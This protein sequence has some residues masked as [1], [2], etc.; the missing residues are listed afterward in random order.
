M[1]AGMVDLSGF[2]V[3]AEERKI[4][5]TR[6]NVEGEYIY[7]G[8]QQR[9][10]MAQIHVYYYDQIGQEK[11]MTDE[12][13]E[14]LTIEYGK[15]ID[16]GASGKVIV[17]AQDESL[18]TGSLEGGFTIKPKKLTADMIQTIESVMVEGTHNAEA[19]VK[20]IDKD[21]QDENR[22][23]LQENKD[24]RVVRFENNSFTGENA[25][26]SEITAKVIIQAVNG[27]NYETESD[28]EKTFQ[29]FKMDLEKLT[30]EFVASISGDTDKLM[31]NGEGEYFK[32]FTGSAVS[33][34]KG[35]E[36]KVYY[37]KDNNPTPLE[38]TDYELNY[39]PNKGNLP[40]VGDVTVNVNV[41]SGK[42]AGLVSKSEQ[43]KFYIRR[44]LTNTEGIS[45]SSSI[46]ASLLD[47]SQAEV[48]LSTLKF[49]DQFASPELQKVLTEHPEEVFVATLQ[50]GWQDELKKGKTEIPWFFDLS[51]K[52]G[53]YSKYYGNQIKNIPVT[54]T[55]PQ[56]TSNMIHIK[57]GVEIRFN[58]TT[59]WLDDIIA[60]PDNYIE[61][62]SAGGTTYTC[63]K[64]Y[65]VEKARGYESQP[66]LNAGTY[67]ITITPLTTGQLRGEPQ[68][69]DIVVEK[70]SLS[71][72]KNIK[73]EVGNVTYTW[74]KISEPSIK[75]QYLN[76]NGD[77][78]PMNRNQDYSVVVPSVNAA[79]DSY[80]LLNGMT[81][82]S[83][84]N[85]QAAYKIEPWDIFAPG[86][87]V[88]LGD[89][90]SELQYNWGDDVTPPGF[91]VTLEGRTLNPGTDYDVIYRNSKGGTTNSEHKYVSNGTITMYV[92]GKGNFTGSNEDSAQSFTIM[93]RE[94]KGSEVAVRA[95]PDQ[96]YT[97]WELKPEIELYRI[98]GNKTI[99]EDVGYEYIN[100]YSNNKDISHGADNAKVVITGNNNLKGTL[101]ASFNIVP[102]DL[103]NLSGL[104]VR[105]NSWDG[106]RKYD[107]VNG[108][109]KENFYIYTGQAI[110]LQ[111]DY[112]LEIRRMID[113]SEQKPDEKDITVEVLSNTEIGKGTIRISEGE[114]GNYTGEKEVYFSIKG[115][116]SDW[117]TGYEGT[118]RTEIE[119]PD[120]VYT[121][122]SIVPQ[123]AVV[124]FRVGDGDTAEIKTLVLG[125]HYTVKNASSETPPLAT[126]VNEGGIAVFTGEDTNDELMFVNTATESFNVLPFDMGQSD[127]VLEA[128]DF[129]AKLEETD[130][131]YSGYPITPKPKITHSGNPV[132]TTT[133]Y[134]LSYYY[135]N[136][137][138]G[139][140][141][142]P[143]EITDTNNPSLFG[144]GDYRVRIT[145]NTNYTGYTEKNY[146][147]SSYEF[148]EDPDADPRVSIVGTEDGYVVLD[149]I[150][151]PDEYSV[152][153]AGNAMMELNEDGEVTDN[154]IWDPNKLK[155]AFTPV[156]MA[157]EAQSPVD[158]VLDKDYYVTYENNTKPG[159][160]TLV[161]HGIGNFAGEIREDFQI[162]ADLGG[163]HTEVRVK[164][165]T[166]TPANEGEEDANKPEVTVWYTQEI[167]GVKQEPEALEADTYTVEYANNESATHPYPG[168]EAESALDPNGNNF[169]Q[170]TVKAK[171]DEY[172]KYTGA[173]FGTKTEGFKIYQRDLSTIRP[174][175][176]TVPE[177]PDVPDI[178]DTSDDSEEYPW[179]I[180]NLQ[181]GYE[182]NETHIIPDPAIFCKQ[183][184][185]N[186]EIQTGDT[187]PSGDY[188]YRIWAE[189]NLNVWTFENDDMSGKRLLPIFTVEARRDAQ[190]KY[191]GNYCGKVSQNFKITPRPLEEKIDT[192]AFPIVNDRIAPKGIVLDETQIADPNGPIGTENDKG[193]WECDY[194]RT[195]ITF[196]TE[197][198]GI[199]SP[200]KNGALH[201]KWSGDGAKY[202]DL[203]EGQDYNIEYVDNV[204]IGDA[205]IHIEAPEISNYAG[206]Y[207]KHFKI[208]ASITEVDNKNPVPPGRYIELSYDA[209]VPYGKVATYPDLIFK[210]MS[211]VFADSRDEAYILEEGEDKD[212]VIITEKNYQKYGLNEYSQNNIEVTD[213][214]AKA[215]VVVQG[216]GYYKGSIKKEYTIVPKDINDPGIAIEF[217]GSI[218]SGEYKN[219]YIYNGNEQEPEINLYNNNKKDMENVDSE[220]PE[221]KYNP[222][223][224][225]LKME[226]VK[227]NNNGTYISGDYRIR[228]WDN[229]V[230]PVNEKGVAKVLIEGVG[231]NYKGERW[232]EFNIILRQ[233]E[234]LTY[235][236]K[237]PENIIY[238]GA[239]QTPE[240]EVSYDD[241][242]KKVIL[243]QGTDYDLEYSN[244]VD[245]SI[246]A[247]APA[248]GEEQP[249]LP[250]ITF[251]G[252]GG[253]DGT[254]EINFDIK[255]RDIANDEVV[256]TAVAMY[257]SGN[258]VTPNI[259]V[260][261]TGILTGVTLDPEKDYEVVADSQTGE[262]GIAE[263]GTVDIT[264]KGNYTGIKKVTFRIIPPDGV[265][266]I[267]EIPE[268]EFT[269]SPIMPEVQVS[270]VSPQIETPFPLNENDYEVRYTDNLKAGTAKVIITG[271]GAFED[272]GAVEKEFTITPKSIGSEGNIDSAMTLS[273][274]EPQWYGGRP[275]VPGVELK[276]QPSSQQPAE[277][278]GEETNNP[279][280]LIQGTDYRVTAVN[281]IMVGEATATITGIG[282]YTGTIETKFRIHGNM[283]LVDVAPIPT[284]DY[285][286][287]PVTPVP[288][289]SIGGKAMVEGTDYRVEYSDN[290]DRGTATITITG[291]E[292]W[293]FGTKVVKFDIARELS[294]ETAV[295]GV[296]AVYTYTGA[297]ITP[298]VRVEDDGNLL[299]SG[300]DY[301]IA[302][303]ENVNA[304]TATITIT[305]KGKYT[306]GTTA[307]FKISPQ[308]LGR[309]KISPVADQIF[310]G[311]EQN[312]PI[313]VT[314]GNIT[315]QDGK[316]YSVVYVNSATPGMAS[317]IVK[318]EGNYTGTQTV[319]YHIKV[320]EITGVKVSKYT[321]K[322]MTL[323]WTKNDVVSGY[324][325]YNSKNRR[326]ARVNKPTTAKGTVS[327]LKAGTAQT[328]RVRA[329]V[330]KDGQ[331]YYGP[332]SSV[333]G[334]TAPDSTKISS[335]KSAKKKQVTVKW[336]KVKGATQYEV[337][338]SASKKGKYKKLATTKKTSYTDKKA[339]GGK[340]YYY[341]IRVCKKIDKK[342]YYSSYSAAKSVKA[343]K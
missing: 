112:N 53:N 339:T 259:T 30:I 222:Y 189:N 278:E 13:K 239:A 283:N 337:Y 135:Y 263:E 132:E 114:S 139:E 156:N 216:V 285:T 93:P 61:V 107:F 231:K 32:I 249:L 151:Y 237:E 141:Q 28:L 21:I 312:P 229:N 66:G 34:E 252:K 218:V 319:N 272:M 269:N 286:G 42:Y 84:T 20:L 320:P 38:P 198:K 109:W 143:T 182:Y 100:G 287:S 214:G 316:D 33:L 194:T 102:C 63:G 205:K 210:D 164:E 83:G 127:A 311:K 52:A 44:L 295:R 171:Q 318:G 47:D 199:Q 137:E 280:T 23:Q 144:V 39:S 37:D 212:F 281:N 142:T 294:S 77:W 1:I 196:P 335:L 9:P 86:N 117:N 248:E 206:S 101:N 277:R 73:I 334:A 160:A 8:T 11:E 67:K 209:E 253:Y 247:E 152:S 128:A 274:I 24:F 221:K 327:K 336:K 177:S 60:N 116:L 223:Q 161:V 245:V 134:D 298:P 78:T 111:K 153:Y 284:Q 162:L 291:T 323:S 35:E 217:V 328:F 180:E 296:A 57:E 4:E 267:D 321:N 266:T 244:N 95:I 98:S 88:E 342:N 230:G 16:A 6:V 124:K 338:R 92:Q 207:D 242:G 332:F 238:N 91:T 5:L 155:I 58:G 240:V 157:G 225:Q 289:V 185:L 340:K 158:L 260:K 288:Q 146:T 10:D 178:P 68:D 204:K 167:A 43:Y 301:D 55:V 46:T 215:T 308:Q 195:F 246:Q 257:N 75:L 62:K 271:T 96:T 208:M 79:G 115:D 175:D 165:C 264:G 14:K 200:E 306:G 233:M 331:Y 121:N 99:D 310:N 119:I 255:P 265:L 26:K 179:Q 211:G 22:K 131:I 29:V 81:N 136:P 181:A 303:S 184:Q 299:I 325:I 118:K 187:E 317:V 104:I 122:A 97:G 90:P 108:N 133:G 256:A 19:I 251:T 15:N 226:P 7:D 130:Y 300:V 314:S 234:E 154:V 307:S 322:S 330:N 170:A 292:D 31:D 65:K 304:G 186:G 145:G 49:V 190:Q 227:E 203:I 183:V 235:T 293:Y 169:G 191:N 113:S 302:Y 87:R 258:P 159:T 59:R 138:E 105:A 70:I 120:Q 27:G 276:F 188:D 192:E 279:V 36:V 80:V 41:T 273:S 82:F 2:T 275:I 54:I 290:I 40:Y 305:G 125:E 50:R 126:T 270:L 224:P 313:T 129:E 174:E 243:T 282:N 64:D 232:F 149:Q 163:T 254:H 172:G 329:Y 309:A 201:I 193:E 123:D 110:D 89:V 228:R 173:V 72:E 343:K 315:L 48:D 74:N 341:K 150:K 51:I 12:E 76:G 220:D 18:Y 45:Y 202:T 166:F 236:I 140:D 25:G 56:L 168:K 326:A 176:L 94:L 297:A 147:I 241:G 85:V 324:E 333:K 17:T 268:Q 103:S 262:T 219:A 69:V 250:T 3:H 71:D 261:D 213:D 197:G 148:N 106:S